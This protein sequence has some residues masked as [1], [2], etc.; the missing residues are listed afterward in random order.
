MA[1]PCEDSELEEREI[2]VQEVVS[3]VWRCLDFTNPCSNQHVPGIILGTRYGCGVFGCD[4]VGTRLAPSS[5][6]TVVWWMDERHYAAGTNISTEALGSRNPRSDHRDGSRVCCRVQTRR[7]SL[8]PPCLHSQSS[9][10]VATPSALGSLAPCIPQ[11]T[12]R[13]HRCAH[14]VISSTPSCCM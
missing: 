13:S 12:S 7:L 3:D 1:L 14:L 9:L 10:P 4:S 8:L 2:E 11:A 6:G 5:T